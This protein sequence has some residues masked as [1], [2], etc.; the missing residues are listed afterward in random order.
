MLPLHRSTV[1]AFAL[2][3]LA[4][5]PGG[6]PPSSPAPTIPE[7][8]AEAWML[9]DATHD[10]VLASRDGDTRRPM[11]S[12]TK[13]MTALVVRDHVELDEQT[14]ISQTAAAVGESE[15]GLAPREIWEVEEL[16]EAMLIRSGNDAAM[17]LAELVGGSVSG[18]IDLMNV[19]AAELGLTNSHFTNP[20][21]LD[22]P[23]H[24]SSARDLVT[25][26]RTALAD[27]I[28]ARIA[29]TRLI[30]FKPDPAGVERKAINTNKLLGAFPGVVGMKTGFTGRAGR[31]LISVLDRTDRVLIAV[32][33][34]SDDHFADSRELLEYGAR[35]VTIR[36]R[37][38]AIAEPEQGGTGVGVIPHADP[39]T[40]AAMRS[41]A[42]LSDG[43]SARTDFVS[44]D[45][46]LRIEAWLRNVVPV[47]AG[48]D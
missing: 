16:L 29:R 8:T 28:L 43:Q 9:Y 36:D 17:A 2:V 34:G 33:L 1:A 35:T 13:V 31:V 37:V 42:P 38:L 22:H 47:I 46:G 27:P 18:F 15:I 41:L 10:V 48:G 40:R 44:T 21:G 5:P 30:R 23:E 14:R 32:V 24:Y 20:H 26:A 6:F 12:V 39:A 45:L 7:L 3:A 19:K 25:L 4:P 11:A